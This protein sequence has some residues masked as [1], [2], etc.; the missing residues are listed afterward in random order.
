[1]ARLG[2]GRNDNGGERGG[3]QSS[4]VRGTGAAVCKRAQRGIGK[5]LRATVSMLGARPGPNGHRSVTGDERRWQRMRVNAVQQL[6]CAREGAEKGIRGRSSLRFRRVGQWARGEA[7][8]VEA[9][10][11]ISGVGRLKT[12]AWRRSGASGVA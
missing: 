6:R 11:E 12:T 1:M 2:G 3:S 8:A 7:G 10:M 4:G 9:A 5:T